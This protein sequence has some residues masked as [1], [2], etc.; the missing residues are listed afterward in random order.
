MKIDLK[1]LNKKKSPR[2]PKTLFVNIEGKFV[3][4][5]TLYSGTLE[6]SEMKL[7]FER[8]WKGERWAQYKLV[9]L[10]PKGRRRMP[11]RLKELKRG[12]E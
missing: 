4:G 7:R 3:R 10:H 6:V 1:K 11:K 12:A 9:K 5:S 8:A 2:Y